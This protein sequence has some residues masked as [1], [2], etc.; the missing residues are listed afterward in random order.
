MTTKE[1]NTFIK[2]VYYMLAYAFR[3]LK[4]DEYEDLAGEDFEHIH[5]LFA[6]ILAKGIARQVKQGLYREYLGRTEDLTTVRGKIELQGTLRNKMGRRQRIS[7]EYDELS[8]NNLHNQVLKTTS[9]ILLR[10]GE[11]SEDHRAGLRKVMLYFSDVDEIGPAEI[12]W[13]AIRFQRSN[14]SY[15]FL[16]SICRLVLDGMLITTDE[17]KRKLARFVDDQKMEK[18]Y[19]KFILEYYKHEHPEL[20]AGAPYI[21]W[22]LDDG[23]S[24]M[25]PAMHTDI[26]LK[27]GRTVLIIDAKF[28]SSSMQQNFDKQSVRSGNLYQIF[29]YVKNKEAELAST[30]G[31]HSVSGMLL[32]AKTDEEIQ[33]DGI[34]QMS[35]NQISVKTLDLDQPF[36]AIRSQLDG[37][38]EAH[39]P[40]ETTY[41]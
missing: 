1:K 11:F 24:D 41:V 38:A 32:Y 26:T 3:S 36:E 25:L 10:H 4:L 31:S 33:P 9:M 7:C 6:V 13:D 19:E 30:P 39:F 12:R 20:S 17:G 14:I 22:A 35:G 34:Y 18:L 16:L 2:N 23:F 5:D 8:E 29:T 40:K 28:Y 37:I 15:R 21:T 27:Q